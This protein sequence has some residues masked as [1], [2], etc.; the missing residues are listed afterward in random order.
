MALASLFPVVAVNAKVLALGSHCADPLRSVACGGAGRVANMG[1][2]SA[3]VRVRVGRS[4][5]LVDA[6]GL[7]NAGRAFPVAMIASVLNFRAWVV[8]LVARHFAFTAVGNHAS[9]ENGQL[10]LGSISSQEG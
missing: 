6:L 10:A 5:G 7:A 8:V 3:I 9:A 4:S 1:G 2:Q